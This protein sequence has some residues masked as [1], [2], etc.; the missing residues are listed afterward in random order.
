MISMTGY[1]YAERQDER[2]SAVVEVK[3]YN[4][5]YLDLNCSLP[6]VLSQLEAQI[7]ERVGSVAR[8]GRVELFVRFRDKEEDLAVTV[9][10]GVV[11]G[12]LKAFAELQELTGD[13]EPVQLEHLLSREGVLKS[14]RVV[15]TDR[16]W[17]VVEPLLDE[18]LT[19]FGATRQ[20]EGAR[21]ALDIE[22]QL[23]KIDSCVRAFENHSGE[24]EDTI[25]NGLRQRFAEVFGNDVDENRVLAEVAV[26]LTRFSINEEIVRLRAHLDSFREIGF[27]GAEAGP[28]V[29]VG[30]KLDFLCQE[31]N[32]EIN[33]TGSKSIILEVNQ[34]VVEAKDALENVREQLR[35]V[36]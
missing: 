18:A 22:N 1:G 26:Q 29:P 8:R 35:N 27:G 4:N 20:A 11:N 14:E 32:R 24:I 28:D 3:S 23:A 36:E 2:F 12:Y 31:L 19:G 21:L 15:D 17:L 25:R 30:K 7:R 6:G 5:R 33:T 10:K 13:S 16:A 9:D 34:Q